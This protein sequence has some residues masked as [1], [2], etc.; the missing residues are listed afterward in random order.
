MLN[1]SISND[2]KDIDMKHKNFTLIEL[3]VVIAIIAI[4]ASLLL[5]AL[6]NAR[7]TARRAVCKSNLKQIGLG[8]N[9]Y[10]NDYN[11]YPTVT[12]MAWGGDLNWATP[13][14]GFYDGMGDYI[15]N[16]EIFWC[17]SKTSGIGVKPAVI[18]KTIPA[19]PGYAMVLGYNQAGWTVKAGVDE[20]NGSGNNPTIAAKMQNLKGVAICDIFSTHPSWGIAHTQRAPA[21]CNAL[22]LAGHVLWVGKR[23][24]IYY[25]GGL[26][27]YTANG[28]YLD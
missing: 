10:A 25:G 4:L 1:L 23:N 26:E 8:M 5:P 17:S 16:M 14:Y 9:M 13:G 15:K 22:F 11:Y 7:E 21:G 24:L 2:I 20:K 18:P 19:R 6:Q 28:N 27:W 12:D 3:L